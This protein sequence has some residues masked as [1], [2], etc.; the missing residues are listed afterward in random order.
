MDR[1]AHLPRILASYRLVDTRILASYLLIDTKDFPA[2]LGM[3]SAEFVQK[4][5]WN[6]FNAHLPS[7][8]ERLFED[9]GLFRAAFS[10]P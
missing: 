10:F 8:L 7:T 9:L 3:I 4:V 1:S 6:L 5:W 2:N